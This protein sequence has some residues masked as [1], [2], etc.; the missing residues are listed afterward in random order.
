MEDG[1]KYKTR[2]NKVLENRMTFEGAGCAGRA[3]DTAP[4]NENFSIITD[5]HNVFDRNLYRVPRGVEASRFVW[6]HTTY[7]WEGARDRGFEPNGRLL[8]F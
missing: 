2:N 1:E 4:G 5:G 8:T 6:G 7:D 3:S